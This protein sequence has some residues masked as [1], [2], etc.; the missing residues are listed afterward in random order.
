MS[1]S[2]Q[3]LFNGDKTLAV[4]IDLIEKAVIP[5]AGLGTRLLPATKEQPKEMLPLYAKGCNGETCLKPALQL[6]F[7]QLYD[8]GIREFCFVVGR[9][10]RAIEDHFTQDNSYAGYLHGKGRKS[11]A[12]DLEVFYKRLDNSIISWVNQPEPRGFGDAVLRARRVVGDEDFLLHAGDA[13]VISRGNAHFK[14]LS[15]IFDRTRPSAVLLIH[16]LADPRQK[17]V[18]EVRPLSGDSYEVIS[19]EEK[20][21]KPRTSLCIEPVYLFRRHFIEALERTKPGK[22]GELQVTDAIQT[23]ISEGKKVHATKLLIDEA[24]LDVG[25]AKSYWEAF[26]T[27]H[28]LAET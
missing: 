10:K 16:E 28:K 1:K 17:G 3:G 5:A 14:R 9:G 8:A 11:A 12:E 20:P 15:M 19:V 26:S 25:D 18:A 21:E 23:M 24:R 22:G 4:D 7:E 13:F 6:I 2:K 27:S